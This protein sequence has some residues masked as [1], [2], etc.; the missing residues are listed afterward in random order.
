[1]ENR[2]ADPDGYESKD[3]PRVRY[4]I[5]GATGKVEQRV[6]SITYD[7]KFRRYWHCLAPMDQHFAD[8]I[9][10]LIQRACG[11]FY[12]DDDD[13]VPLQGVP[14]I[15]VSDEEIRSRIDRLNRGEN[16]R[17]A[18][19]TSQEHYPLDELPWYQQRALIEQIEALKAEWAF[20][21]L[22]EE[23]QREQPR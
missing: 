23:E 20:E 22:G 9:S 3:L 5:R 14:E 1:M 21:I 6:T 17:E 16:T 11:Y 4:R 19:R 15:F 7:S 10:D 12:Q 18:V 13:W 2:W 8:T